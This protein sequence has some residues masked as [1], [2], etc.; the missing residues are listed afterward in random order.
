MHN[1][2]FKR[3]N[4]MKKTKWNDN[5]L[6]W[7]SKDAFALVWSIPENA[8]KITLPHDAMIETETHADSLNGGNTGF[9]DGGSYT[10]VKFFESK[11]GDRSRNIMLLFEGVY[12]NTFV[13]VNG[14]LAANRPYGYSEF[15][16][17]ISQFFKEEGENEIRVQVRNNACQ[18]SR[19]YT[20]SGIYR[21]VYLLE[22]DNTYI[23]ENSFLITTE[24]CNEEE[25]TVHLKASVRNADIAPKDLVISFG[26]LDR[27]GELIASDQKVISAKAN[28]EMTVFSRLYVDKPSLWSDENPALYKA[29]VTVFEAE[30]ENDGQTGCGE[31]L[32]D[33]AEIFGIRKLRLD[34]KH[35]LRV[36]G[37]SVKLR[38][39]CIHHDSGI[40]GAK[41][42]YEAEYRRV[43]ILKK[44]GFNAIRMSHHPTAPALVKA[45]DELGMYIM[46]EAFDMWTRAKSDY[47]YNM[48]F[49]DWWERDV[50]AMVMKDYN[51]PSVILY[52]I[53]NEIPEIGTD[54]GSRL[55]AKISGLCHKLDPNRY[56]LASINGVF[57]AGDAV[58]KITADVAASVE[59]GDDSINVNDF[60]T[61]MDKYMDKIVV[62]PE[63]TKRLHKACA[64]TDIAGYNYMTARY[65]LDAKKAPNRVIVGSETYPPE[66]AVNWREVTKYPQVIGDFTWTG[67]DYLG[68]AGVGIPA[69]KFGEGGF[70][71]QFPAKLAYTGD[72]DITGFRRPLSYYREIVFGLRKA[73]YI[74]VQDPAHYGEKLIKTPWVMS[75]TVSGWTFSGYENKPVVVEVYSSGDEVELLL[76]EKS[77]GKKKVVE[78]DNCRTLFETTYQLGTLKAVAYKDGENIGEYELTTAVGDMKLFAEVDGN[79]LEDSEIV[80]V[81]LSLQD[82]DGDVFINSDQSIT[83]ELEG[84]AELLGFGSG[85]PKEQEPYSS[86]T[87]NTWNGRALAIVRK[88][89]GKK[90]VLK[91]GIDSGIKTEIVL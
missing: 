2:V 39:A 43:A 14:Q 40:L 74:A 24:E 53:G 37:K 82:S 52:S 1:A 91:A 70:G 60:M 59:D 26:I 44:A 30:E 36:N 6:F 78:E 84:D 86:N 77:I 56:T 7:N 63:I 27:N 85:N 23:K 18:N 13:Y 87:S 3:W 88:I 47:D 16:V 45:C 46:D 54:E 34:A 51:H 20:G 25:A 22:A 8:R 15:T 55:A 75:D 62:H 19:W 61:I 57:A 80:Y 11:K 89:P 41:T 48:Y 83:L 28:S 71:A 9:Y 35:G 4:I 31:S 76:D 32:D 81:N 29:E 79:I 38:G 12:M 68:E 72:I 42:F 50:E 65:S 49:M 5:W 21:D 90:V 33:E 64:A 73:P 17:P 67:W 69:Y 66:I 58:P 10:Y